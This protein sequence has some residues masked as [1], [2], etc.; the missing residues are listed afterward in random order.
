MSARSCADDHALRGQHARRAPGCRRCRRATA[1]GRSRRWRCSA[2]P[3]RSSARRTAPTRPVISCRVG[4]TAMGSR[5]RRRAAH[6]RRD[7]VS[8]ATVLRH[9]SPCGRRPIARRPP[10]RPTSLWPDDHAPA[11]SAARTR[12]RRQPLRPRRPRARARR[13]RRRGCSTSATAR[14]RCARC[15]SV[16]VG[17]GA[18]GAGRPPTRWATGL[19]QIGGAGLSAALAGT[20]LWLASVCALQGRARRALAPWPRAAGRCCSAALGGAGRL[21]CCC[22][23]WAWSTP[24]PLRRVAPAAGRRGAAPALVWAWLDSARA[25]AHAGRRH[26]RGW[27]NC[28]RASA[29]TSCSTRSTP[30]SR[31]CASTPQ[32]A[33]GVLEDLAELFR[34]A[35]AETARVGHA[36]RRDRPGA[37]LP[38]DRAGALRRAAGGAAGRST[39]P[40]SRRACR[41]WCCSRWWRTPCATASRPSRGRRHGAACARRCAAARRVVDRNTL[42]R[43]ARRARP[44]HGAGQ[45]ARAAAPAARRGRAVRRLAR[46]AAAGPRAH[47]RAAVARRASRRPTCCSV[48]IVDDERWRGMRLRA[49]VAGLRRAALRGGGRGGRCARSALQW[50]REQRVPTWCCSTSRCRARDGTAA[51]RRAAT[52][53]RAAGGGVRH[54]ARRACAGG[55]RTRGRR[56]PDQ[57]GAAR[58]AAGRAAA[59]GRSAATA[60]PS[61]RRRGA[62]AGGQRPRPRAAHAGWPTCCT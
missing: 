34:V 19:A 16:Q 18:G 29:R 57:A 13:C 50:L 7:P 25:A 32:R 33:E 52:P 58:A 20:L 4:S 15:C 41:R 60:S 22:W 37:A 54:R 45:R 53:A 30:R 36:G 27:P 42:P 6:D 35:L 51:G 24:R 56:L 1:A 5:L 10:S 17:A 47:R 43:R 55:L 14:W 44:R 8:P 49:L 23:R 9:H 3:A 31:W 12:L 28:S 46:A 62:G 48:L 39:R 21:G 26:A 2:A 40:P 61:R 38:G 11:T 59:R